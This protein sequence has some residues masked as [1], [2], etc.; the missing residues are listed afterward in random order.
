VFIAP[1]DYRL[2]SY[3]MGW[4]IGKP[5]VGTQ[6]DADTGER[7]EVEHLADQ[8]FPGTLRQALEAIQDT[9]LRESDAESFAELSAELKSFRA[10]LAGLFEIQVRE[11]KKRGRRISPSPY[12]AG[13]KR[14]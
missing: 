13:R 5:R 7:V 14:T 2:E 3:P 8:R 11:P 10:E 6:K 9:W 12:G 4:T 1:G